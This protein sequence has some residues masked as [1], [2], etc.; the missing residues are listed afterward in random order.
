[1]PPRKI[2]RSVLWNFLGAY[3]SR[4]TDYEGYWLFGFLVP[5][6]NCLEIDLLAAHPQPTTTEETA[7]HW[8][9]VKFADQLNK[10][11]IEKSRIHSARLRITHSAQM[12][13]SQVYRVIPWPA[14]DIEREGYTVSLLAEARLDAG[15]HFAVEREM[16]VAPH[17]PAFEIRSQSLP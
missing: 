12:I 8:A 7:A 17:D 16:F 13:R 2:L 10:A 3:M 5:K 6:P 9:E 14:H 11:S 4:Y 15:Q 1:M